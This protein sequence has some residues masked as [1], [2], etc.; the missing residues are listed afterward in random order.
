[1]R[2]N[3][4]FS[5][6]SDSTCVRLSLNSG[7]DAVDVPSGLHDLLTLIFWIFDC[8]ITYRFWCIQWLRDITATSREFLSGDSRETRNLQEST[9]SCATKSWKLHWN[10]WELSRASAVEIT[11]ISPISQQAACC[12]GRFANLSVYYTPLNHVT[13]VKH[14]YANSVSSKCQKFRP[15]PKFLYQSVTSL[16]VVTYC[17]TIA[18]R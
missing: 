16:C 18:T 11:W 8:R 10:V 14:F 3:L 7:Y 2:Y 13:L 9:H 17:I 5:E 4:I 1:M 6:F 12:L 15:L